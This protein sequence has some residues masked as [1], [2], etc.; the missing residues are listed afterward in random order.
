[1]LLRPLTPGSPDRAML[2]VFSST[3]ASDAFTEVLGTAVL[4][5]F[6]AVRDEPPGTGGELLQRVPLSDQ[7]AAADLADRRVEERWRKDL[8]PHA[9][10]GGLPG[11]RL[12]PTAVMHRSRTH[13]GRW[14]A[15]AAADRPVGI[16]LQG[17]RMISAR[18]AQH[19]CLPHE[20]PD[21]RSRSYTL[22]LDDS[23]APEEVA[24]GVPT[25]GR[26]AGHSNW[27]QTELVR[28]WT[29]KE[30]VFKASPRNKDL[31]LSQISVVQPDRLV[32][33]AVAGGNRGRYLI[34]SLAMGDT[35]PSLA[36]RRELD[37]E[38]TQQDLW[39]YWGWLTIAIAAE[40]R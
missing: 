35:L 36:A 5:D 40:S 8:E 25:S 17:H 37:K 3:S 26:E 24:G 14:A 32:G 15:V 9:K 27:Q 6:E 22:A 11:E 16:D 1:M 33:A 18:A 38:G 31:S 34:A 20:H 28:L 39:A 21:D 10:Q 23:D 7:R 30:A 2:H 12:E 29:I 13:S 4:V 19:F